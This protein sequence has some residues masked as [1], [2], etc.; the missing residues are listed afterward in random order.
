MHETRHLCTGLDPINAQYRY[1]FTLKPLLNERQQVP[2][3]R[4]ALPLAQ[5]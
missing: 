1:H 4:L 2:S 3:V 5:G